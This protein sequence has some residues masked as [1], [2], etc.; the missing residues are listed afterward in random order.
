M[1]DQ[2]AVTSTRSQYNFRMHRRQYGR[3]YLFSS[4][5]FQFTFNN[6]KRN[7]INRCAIAAASVNA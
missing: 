2:L 6:N 3:L 4:L 1:H 5:F 7:K